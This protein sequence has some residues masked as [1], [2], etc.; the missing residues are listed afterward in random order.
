MD[1][2][3]RFTEPQTFPGLTPWLCE[4]DGPDGRFGIVLHG[5]DAKS[6][7]REWCVRLPNLTVLGEHGGTVIGSGGA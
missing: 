7:L 5:A 2:N 3:G 1:G 4:Y 6:I